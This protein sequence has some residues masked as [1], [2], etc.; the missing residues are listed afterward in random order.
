MNARPRTMTPAERFFWLNAGYS[1]DPKTETKAQGRRRCAVRLAEAEAAQRESGS[2]YAWQDDW[3]VNHT[4]E[5][6][7]EPKTCESVTLWS[8]D[9]DRVLASLGCIDDATEEYRRV[10][11][12]E[13]ADEA[14]F[15]RRG[16]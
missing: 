6:G 14:G 7:Y 2:T 5:F 12:A 3:D 15:G 13:L 8:S 11:E 9:G 1:F 4:K 16:S 10:V